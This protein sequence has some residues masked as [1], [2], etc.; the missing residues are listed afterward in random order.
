MKTHTE[1]VEYYRTVRGD[2]FFG[3]T[4]EV[5]LPFLPFDQVK[6]F[7]KST[8]IAEKW[9]EPEL[10]THDNIISQMREYMKFALEKAE[11]H[12]GISAG[13]SIEKMLA[14]LWLLSDEE[15]IIFAKTDGHYQNYGVPILKCIAEKYDFET[16]AGESWFE[17]MAQ[18]RPCY[19]GCDEG[20]GK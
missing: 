4:G 16:P 18:G 19:P 3:F 10:L 8:A 9:E 6:E 2:D 15:I 13:R 17:N 5:L 20:C 1:I 14:W 12:R 11:N 7:L